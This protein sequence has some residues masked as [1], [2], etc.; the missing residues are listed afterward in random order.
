MEKSGS[1]Q[2][3]ERALILLEALSEAPEGMRLSDL[4]RK[5]GLAASTSHRLLTT[6][7]KRSFAQFDP[8]RSTW[9]VGRRAF[10]VGSAYMRWQSFIAAAMPYLRQLRDQTRETAN[11]GVL[12][13]GSVIT[14]A[15]VESR[16]IIRAI[17]PPGGRAPV[18]NSGM[19]KAIVATWPDEAIEALVE[20]HGLRPFTSRSLKT[21]DEVRREM[22]QIRAQGYAFDDEEYTL[23][24]R[25]VAAVVWSPTGEP[26]GALSISALAARLPPAEMAAMGE[27][28]RKMALELSRAMG[29]QPPEAVSLPLSV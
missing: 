16:E 27:R 7:E 15:Q 24:M 4:A 19:G 10:L 23:G 13:E 8:I 17:A 20:R 21:M 3:V 2:A 18:M 25:C 12:E 26:I 14:V 5:L 1:V 6:L 22:A 11:L 29:G 28:L 9:H